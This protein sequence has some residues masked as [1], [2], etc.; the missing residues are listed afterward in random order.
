MILPSSGSDFYRRADGCDHAPRVVR[1][2]P[3]DCDIVDL[4][5]IDG[6]V[7][8]RDGCIVDEI[9][10]LADL[11]DDLRNQRFGR[12]GISLSR[13]DGDST[14]P[15][16]PE[17]EDDAFRLRGRCDVED[18]NIRALF[19]KGYRGSGAETA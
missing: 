13:V 8:Q 16:R 19:R 1:P 2:L 10:Q 9:V 3:I 5:V 11:L 14:D 17:V 15:F 4:R 7:L 6:L 12:C 18:R